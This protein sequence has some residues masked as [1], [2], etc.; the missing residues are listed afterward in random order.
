VILSYVSII[1]NYTKFKKMKSILVVLFA[2]TLIFVAC[3]SKNETNKDIVGIDSAAYY[4][5]N[6]M[7]DTAKTEALAPGT[8]KR[9]V[10]TRNPDGTITTVTTTSNNKT[11][12]A[13]KTGTA[14]TSTVASTG[15][16]STTTT[17]T[18][19]KGWSSRAKGA[20]IG[21]VGGA[22]VGAAVSKKKG[23][24]AV[25]GGVVGAAGGYIIGNEK[26][27]KDGR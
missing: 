24:G 5:N 16:G 10:E 4:K 9:V 12:S 25:I 17:T 6:M 8:T 19:K 1:I 21:G 13:T 15:T 14:R 27:K 7:A 26:D 22:V 2:F 20:V 3:K 18:A 23:K 11:S